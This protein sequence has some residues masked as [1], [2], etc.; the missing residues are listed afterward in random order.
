MTTYQ[1]PAGMN[2]PAGQQPGREVKVAA[3]KLRK[4]MVEAHVWKCCLNCMD[5][6]SIDRIEAD[7]TQKKV[8]FCGRYN[9]AP[10]PLVIVTGCVDYE[11]DIPF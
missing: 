5:W 6:R 10:P 9:V 8:E 1:K 3:V 2:L 11:Q 7:G 4:D